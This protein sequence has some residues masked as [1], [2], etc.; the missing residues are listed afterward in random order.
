MA[1]TASQPEKPN[2]MGMPRNGAQQQRV[3]AGMVAEPS[4]CVVLGWD[5]SG[6]VLCYPACGLLP[7]GVLEMV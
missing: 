7:A 5:D 2:P 1:S 6:A 3:A 4:W